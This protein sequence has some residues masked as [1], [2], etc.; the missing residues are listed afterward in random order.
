MLCILQL[1]P[2]REAASIPLESVRI[3]NK[4]LTEVFLNIAKYGDVYGACP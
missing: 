1:L 3:W 4:K 2:K